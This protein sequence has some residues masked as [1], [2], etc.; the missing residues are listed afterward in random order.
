MC[1]EQTD[2]GSGDEICAAV[3][4]GHL[5]RADRRMEGL[6]AGWLGQRPAVLLGDGDQG[7]HL[8]NR[9]PVLT[10]R[11]TTVTLGANS[12]GVLTAVMD[13]TGRMQGARMARLR[14]GKNP[15]P[16]AV[17]RTVK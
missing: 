17:R 14:K 9:K 15:G 1:V 13:S 16:I 6:L 8:K 5:G 2:Y 12:G 10:G 3:P 11:G 7:E 4:A